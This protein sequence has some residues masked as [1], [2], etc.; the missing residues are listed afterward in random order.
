MASIFVNR[1]RKPLRALGFGVAPAT[2]TADASVPR[3]DA[4]SGAPTASRTTGSLYMRTAGQ[5]ADDRLFVNEDGTTQYYPVKFH[6]PISVFRQFDDFLYQTITEADTPWILN[7]GSDA[8]A[9]DPAIATDECGVIRCTSGNNGGGYAADGSQLIGSVPVQA[10]SGGLHFE[11][12][13]RINTAIT[14]AQVCVGLTDVTTLELPV[15]IGGGDALTT[16][17]SDFV[18]F[19][20]DTG[21]DTDEWFGVAVD[22]DTDDT[23]S[24]TTSTAPTADVYQT[25][26]IDVSSDG[27]TILFTIAGTAVLTLTGAAG[28]SPAVNLYPTVIVNATTTTSK[29]VDVDYID[30]SHSR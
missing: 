19:V 22:S 18:G 30:V 11:A 29:V 17:A 16:T 3:I 14:N 1:L 4:G 26:G 8:Q 21:A 9:I 7:S 12:R 25:L 28:V 6:A 24:A 13:V 5:N 27:A 20:Y 23:G 15:S 10:D 2:T